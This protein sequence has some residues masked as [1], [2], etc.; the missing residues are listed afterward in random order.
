MV[1][2]LCQSCHRL[3][4]F[5]TSI[6][7]CTKTLIRL[8]CVKCPPLFLNTFL[9]KDDH[10]RC[11]EESAPCFC[12]VQLAFF[13]IVLFQ[14]SNRHRSVVSIKAAALPAKAYWCIAWLSNQTLC[15]IL[16][17]ICINIDIDIEKLEM[18]MQYWLIHTMQCTII[19]VQQYNAHQYNALMYNNIMHKK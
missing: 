4:K 2:S 1:K 3:L 18:L 8:R 15:A 11:L 9:K 16:A 17:V 7:K 12:T 5:Q 6:R 10:A 13:C 14:C 19:D